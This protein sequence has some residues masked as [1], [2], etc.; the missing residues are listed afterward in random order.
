MPIT[1]PIKKITV[2]VI[3]LIGILILAGT[4]YWISY[5]IYSILNPELM[6]PLENW[7]LFLGILAFP[8]MIA[9]ITQALILSLLTRRRWISFVRG[10]MGVWLFSAI[11][12]LFALF[13]LR[14][15]Y[16]SQ[17]TSGLL[18]VAIALSSL[19]IA[20]RCLKP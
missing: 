20:W 3:I 10:R 1:N 4:V 6:R 7:Y 12:L 5:F 13:F 14:S 9:S 18:Y 8:L 2:G 15:S 19:L 16:P 17:I 11:A